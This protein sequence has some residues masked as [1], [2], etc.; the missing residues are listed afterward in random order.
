[1]KER[2]MPPLLSSRDFQYSH[3]DVE[4]SCHHGVMT[5]PYKIK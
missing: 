1:M 5:L 2:R 3:P 4:F